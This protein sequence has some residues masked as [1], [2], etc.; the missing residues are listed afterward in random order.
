MSL[1]IL[2]MIVVSY[3]S[4]VETGREFVVSTIEECLTKIMGYENEDNNADNAS[5]PDDRNSNR[6]CGRTTQKK[7]P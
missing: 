4:W 3:N 5:A 6:K 2:V 7:I 1:F